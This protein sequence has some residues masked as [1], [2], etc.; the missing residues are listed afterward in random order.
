MVVRTLRYI[1]ECRR[2]GNHGAELLVLFTN[3]KY[4]DK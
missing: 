2:H 4:F 3:M 1:D